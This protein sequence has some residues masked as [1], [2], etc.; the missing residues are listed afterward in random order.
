M[1]LD[2]RPKA[3]LARNQVGVTICPLARNGG[4]IMWLFLFAFTGV[5]LPPNAD[6]QRTHDLTERQFSFL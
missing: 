4:G 5:T 2:E 6:S 1:R 3:G